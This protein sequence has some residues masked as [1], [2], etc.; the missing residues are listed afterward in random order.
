MGSTL[1]RTLVGLGVVG[2]LFLGAGAAV[3]QTAG[4]DASSGTATTT[5]Q[6]TQQQQAPAA[7]CPDRTG[8]QS[9]E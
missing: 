9:T 8:N 1:K 3:A 6:D 2:A 7:D 5:V 4:D